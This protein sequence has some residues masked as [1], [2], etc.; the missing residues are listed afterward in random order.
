[1]YNKIVEILRS[2]FRN[3][4]IHDNLEAYIVAGNPQNAED[5]DRLEKEFNHQRKYLGDWVN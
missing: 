5:V 3:P 2:V 1:M 4:V